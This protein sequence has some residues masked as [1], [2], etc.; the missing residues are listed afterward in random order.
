MKLLLHI[1]YI[2]QAACINKLYPP[3]NS[4]PKL[5]LFTLIKDILA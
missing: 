5:K 3:L 1:Y 4:S 2:Y